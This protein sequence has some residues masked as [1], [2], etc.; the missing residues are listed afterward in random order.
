MPGVA[1][2]FAKK[3]PPAVWTA[4]IQTN[5][6]FEEN[7]DWLRNFTFSSA[8]IGS[9]T[10]MTI[11]T[12]PAQ[13]V[14]QDYPKWCHLLLPWIATQN[15]ERSGNIVKRRELTRRQKVQMPKKQVFFF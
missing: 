11:L 15:M 1:K 9:P 3:T 14:C 6:A 7:K 13:L 5:V 2:S 12:S 8:T 4:E 10:S